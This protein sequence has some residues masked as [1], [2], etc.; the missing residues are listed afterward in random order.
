MKLP[1]Q[2]YSLLRELQRNSK[3]KRNY[4]KITVLLML[5]LGK[6]KEEIAMCLGRSAPSTVRNYEQS[7]E[8]LGFETYLRDHYMGYEGKLTEEEQKVLC[9]ELEENLYKNTANCLF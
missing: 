2:E 4:V 9:A 7:Y 1:D 6:N 3:Q 8:S 5:H